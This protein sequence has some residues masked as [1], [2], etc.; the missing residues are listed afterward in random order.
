MKVTSERKKRKNPEE[1]RGE[2]IAA[3]SCIAIEEGLE[4]LTLRRVA[5]V[6]GIVPGLVNH[7][8]PVADELCAAAFA[9]AAAAERDGIFE[10]VPSDAPPLAQLRQV[11]GLLL[12]DASDAVSLLWLDAWQ[13]TR[14]RPALRAEV[15]R[16]M[17]FWQDR[18][19][20]LIAAGTDAGV[21]KVVDARR[22]AQ[23]CMSLIDGLSIQAAIRE[24]ISYGPVRELVVET[25]ERELGL[26]A[27]AL[28]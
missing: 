17:G 7:Y 9:Y 4:S 28:R 5:E 25:V 19:S 22:T 13:A 12:D 16:Q 10:T 21:F 20:G 15:A 11:L 3:A 26:E 6:L 8:F 27:G 1:R 2:I 18:M 23:R 14:K 24:N